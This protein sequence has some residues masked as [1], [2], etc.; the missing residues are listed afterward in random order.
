MKTKKKKKRTNGYVKV[1]NSKR[2]FLRS[3]EIESI[4]KQLIYKN[5]GL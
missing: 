4:D 1:D 5:I 2:K 3:Y